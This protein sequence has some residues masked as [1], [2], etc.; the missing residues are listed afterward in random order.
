MRN[1]V[2]E[3]ITKIRKRMGLLNEMDLNNLE[4][5][6]VESGIKDD[7]HTSVIEYVIKNGRPNCDEVTLEDFMYN[8]VSEQAYAYC[9]NQNYYEVILS[10]MGK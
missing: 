5:E 6:S 3:E 2:F 7:L 1:N 8:K 4:D 10:G 9:S